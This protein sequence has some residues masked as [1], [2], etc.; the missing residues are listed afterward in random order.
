MK[1]SKFLH[2]FTIEKITLP[3]VAIN[4]ASAGTG[5]PILLLHGHP[6]THIVWRKVAPF[7]V[8]AGY[9]VIAPDLRGYGDSEKPKSDADHLPYSKRVMA[10]DQVALM[11]KLGHERFCV[12]GHDRGGRVAHRM[13]R[14]YPG[15]VK[16]LAVL[17][18]APTDIMYAQTDKEFATRY[19]WWFFLIQPY[20]FP[21]R[22]IASDPEYFLRRHIAG[23]VKIDGAVSNDAMAEYLRTYN[24]PDTIHAICEDYRAS[25]GIDLEHDKLDQGHLIE[26]PLLVIWGAMSVVGDLYDVVET[27]RQKARN[28]TGFALPCGHAIPEEAPDELATKLLQFFTDR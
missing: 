3:G 23:Q 15:V 28:V 13:V 10:Q 27:W 25:A 14:D 22:M 19:F 5:S 16:R 20:D 12:V 17:D 18:I 9:R 1:A 7:L 8:N 24:N 4:Y 26:V 6:Q 2:G 11:A 21:E